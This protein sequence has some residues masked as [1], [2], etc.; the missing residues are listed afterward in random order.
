MKID[1]L[2]KLKNLR[3]TLDPHNLVPE[4]EDQEDGV[5]L[6]ESE[7]EAVHQQLLAQHEQKEAAPVE[8]SIFEEF[9]GPV[10]DE[11]VEVTY[12][13]GVVKAYVDI[14]FDNMGKNITDEQCLAIRQSLRTF[15]RTNNKYE[16]QQYLRDISAIGPEAVEI[17]FRECR[18]FDLVTDEVRAEVIEVIASLAYRNLEARLLVKGILEHSATSSHTL[19]AIGVAGA[20]RDDEMI[21]SLLKHMKNPEYF[22]V[23]L[24]ALLKIRN[25]DSLE[26]IIQSLEE[27]DGSQKHLVDYAILQAKRFKKFGVAAIDVIFHYYQEGKNRALRKVYI[28]AICSFGEDAIPK[29]L[30]AINKAKQIHDLTRL[31]QICM[32]L[33]G[34]RTPASTAV[35]TSALQ[36]ANEKEKRAIIIG[37]GRA[38]DDS[39]MDMIVYELQHTSDIVL[40]SEC[41]NALSF[42]RNKKIQVTEIVKPYL[43]VKENN[44]FLDATCCL[45]RV[46]NQKLL[47]D[48]IEYAINGDDKVQDIAQKLISRLPLREL[49]RVGQRILHSTDDQAL[50]IVTILQRANKVPHELAPVIKEK[51]KSNMTFLLE[52]E[53]YR[54]IAKHVNSNP[55]FLPAEVLYEARNKSTNDRMNRELSNMISKIANRGGVIVTKE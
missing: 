3:Q 5:I 55:P 38:A 52:M 33:G 7:R 19:L 13:D 46:G 36:Q 23:A 20:L 43:Q 15:A 34:L 41:I 21:Y 12:F 50:K 53:I 45:V 2:A 10:N 6:V 26:S 17:I 35:L 31:S 11:V 30:E 54:L 49:A 22:K 18:Q 28:D 51:L 9:A 29:L 37:L 39:V 1:Q 14:S 27:L 40:K 48:L 47:Y 42:F 25:I 44:L 8:M 4:Y 16:R 24:D 32:T